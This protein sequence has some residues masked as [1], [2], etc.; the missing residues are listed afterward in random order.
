MAVA[1][2]IVFVFPV[3]RPER[4]LSA[5]QALEVARAKRDEACGRGLGKTVACQ[6]RQAE[7]AKLETKQAQ[8]TNKV[9]A[10]AK[11]ESA[12]FAKLVAWV[13]HG[14]LQPGAD[15]FDMLWLFFRTLL[16]QV[17]GLVLMLARR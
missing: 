13:S 15:D 9:A 1:F 2:L 8:A 12:D 11:P 3:A 7:V 17:G 14:A 5:D 16:P 6:S 4:F 10:Q